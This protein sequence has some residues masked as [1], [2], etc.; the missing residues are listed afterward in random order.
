MQFHT[1]VHRYLNI[2]ENLYPV[3]KKMDLSDVSNGDGEIDLLIGA[4]YYWTVVEGGIKKCGDGG[5]TAINSKLGWVLNGP[6]EH[7]RFV[8]DEENVFSSNVT[9]TNLIR[10]DGR[11]KFRNG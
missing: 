9:S 3:L 10:G 8:K 2:V 7:G 5:L 1:S 4:D 6:Y 11:C